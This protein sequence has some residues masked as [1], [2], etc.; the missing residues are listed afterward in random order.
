MRYLKKYISA[1]FLTLLPAGIASAQE[2]DSSRKY[3]P[4]LSDTFHIGLGLYRPSKKTEIGADLDLSPDSS[5]SLQ[6]SESQSTGILNFRWRFT[7]NWH[8]KATYWNTDT[9]SQQTL[10][11]DFEFGGETFQAGSFVGMGVDTAITRLF[12]GRSLFRKPNHDWGVG[13][14]MH[15]MEIDAFVEGQILKAGGG[16]TELHKENASASAPLPN[17]GIWYIYSWSPNWAVITRLD[18]LEVSV[19]EFSGNM[20]DASVGVNYQVSDHFGLGLAINGF[21][22]DVE[23]DWTDGRGVFENEQIGPRLNATWSW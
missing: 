4:F 22:L 2:S 9:E 5:D 16:G 1:F 7:E 10:T 15:W 12:W 8:F 3:H 19:D 14:G 13:F 21:I 20:Y 18:W 11:K 23:V 6:S 17:L